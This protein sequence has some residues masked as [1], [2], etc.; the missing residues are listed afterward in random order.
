MCSTV[1]SSTK[2]ANL[3]R[4]GYTFFIGNYFNGSLVSDTDTI[5]GLYQ[6]VNLNGINCIKNAKTGGITQLRDAYH[7]P[8]FTTA[9]PFDY[10]LVTPTPTNTY[11]Q[12]RKPIDYLNLNGGSIGRTWLVV[13]NGVGTN[14]SSNK[15]LNEAFIREF[16]SYFPNPLGPQIGILS[17][18]TDYWNIVGTTFTIYDSNNALPQLWWSDCSTANQDYTGFTPFNNWYQPVMHRYNCSMTNIAGQS[19]A[20]GDLDWF[21]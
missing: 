8:Q 14:W 19:G 3:K 6:G 4:A 10:P 12:A 5:D 18:Y 15:T 1:I 2:F 20:N 7:I 21:A 11:A 16:V 17:T 13:L 9:K